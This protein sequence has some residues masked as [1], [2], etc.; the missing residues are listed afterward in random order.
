MKDHLAFK[1]L[2]IILCACALL[3]SVGSVVGIVGFVG[4]GLY[5]RH[6]FLFRQNRNGLDRSVRFGG[7]LHDQRCCLCQN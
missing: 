5:L 6:C 3:V 1:F 7:E 4:I 2:A